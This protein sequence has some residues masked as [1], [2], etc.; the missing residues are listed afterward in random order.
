MAWLCKDCGYE[1]ENHTEY[2]LH[3][4]A[5][6]GQPIVAEPIEETPKMAV[7]EEVVQIPTYSNADKSGVSEPSPTKIPWSKE[8]LAL[9]ERGIVLEY[10]FTGL[11]PECEKEVETLELPNLTEKDKVAMVAYCVSCKKQL[12]TE[13]VTKL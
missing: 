8:H 10:R 4:A 5:H 6:V 11:C 13:V 12:Q 7:S 9:K 3:I 2:K 1:T